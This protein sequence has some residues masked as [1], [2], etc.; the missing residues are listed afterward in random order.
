MKFDNGKAEKLDKAAIE[1][2]KNKFK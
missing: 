2:K 1:E